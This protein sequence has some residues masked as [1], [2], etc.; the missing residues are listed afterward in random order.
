M[1]V[2]VRGICTHVCLVG[3]C[4]EYREEYWCPALHLVPLRQSLSLKL[5][6]FLFS[7]PVIFFSASIAL[8][9]QAHP[10]P[11]LAFYTCAGDSDPG[12][13]TCEAMPLTP[14]TISPALGLILWWVNQKFRERMPIAERDVLKQCKHSRKQTRQLDVPKTLKYDRWNIHNTKHTNFRTSKV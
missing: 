7:S 13:H 4:A 3:E 9:L 10:R 6:L 11:C 14:W 2:C 8:G 12:P 5:E 1:Y